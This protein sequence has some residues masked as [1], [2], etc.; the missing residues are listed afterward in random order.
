MSEAFAEILSN[1]NTPP[2]TVLVVLVVFLVAAF[3]RFL[4]Y[5]FGAIETMVDDVKEVAKRGTEVIEDNSR[6]Q[7]QVLEAL[8]RSNGHTT[9]DPIQHVEVS[10]ADKG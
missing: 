5:A 2:L 3:L 4:R 9:L 7:G 6:I 1:P 10:E 8:H